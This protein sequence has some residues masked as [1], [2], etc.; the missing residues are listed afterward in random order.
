VIYSN[1]ELAQHI[2]W[3][4]DTNPQ[5]GEI[6]RLFLAGEREL[7]Q[8]AHARSTAIVALTA[9]LEAAAHGDV[10][11]DR[12]TT[13]DLLITTNASSETLLLTGKTAEV[14]S[15]YLDDEPVS[16]QDRADMTVRRRIA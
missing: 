1:A 16:M 2:I 13:G 12:G 14:L 15:S 7:L 6:A 9:F 10:Y 5:A 8:I 4:L 11:V 3:T